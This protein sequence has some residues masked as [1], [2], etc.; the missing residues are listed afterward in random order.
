MRVSTAHVNAAPDWQ[1]VSAVLAGCPLGPPEECEDVQ[2][3]PWRVFPRLWLLLLEC[4]ALAPVG[5]QHA[6]EHASRDSQI[7]RRI[8]PYDLEACVLR[9]RL[10]TLGGVPEVIMRGTMVLLDE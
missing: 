4:T 7:P 2:W 6:C 8:Q 5:Q 3:V 10:G 1:T 9:E